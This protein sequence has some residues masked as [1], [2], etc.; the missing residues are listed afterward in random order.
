MITQEFILERFY[1]RD[2]LL[3]HT[4]NHLVNQ[5]KAGDVAGCLGS[6]GYLQLKINNKSY[7]NHRIVFLMFNGFLPEYV[8]HIDGIRTNN[9]LENLRECTFSQNRCNTKVYRN[10]KSGIKGINW[11]REHGKWTARIQFKNKRILVGRFS[12]LNDAKNAIIERRNSLHGEF[13]N[14]T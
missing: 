5:V 1:Y 3:F 14:N 4:G 9:K 2:G 11:D 13:A 8:D 6:H 10:N 7:L 12:Q